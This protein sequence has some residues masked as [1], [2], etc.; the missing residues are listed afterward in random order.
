MIAQLM[1]AGNWLAIGWQ[2]SRI[3]LNSPSWEFAASYLAAGGP[4]ILGITGETKWL[5]RGL[6][7]SSVN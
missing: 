1:A 5:L 3:P 4:I 6:E 7:G 2:A